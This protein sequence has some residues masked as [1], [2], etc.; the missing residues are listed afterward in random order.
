MLPSVNIVHLD[1]APAAGSQSDQ[2]MPMSPI[3][4]AMLPSCVGTRFVLCI[5]LQMCMMQ[6]LE[7]SCMHVIK[8]LDLFMLVMLTPYIK[9][10]TD[11]D[12]WCKRILKVL[13]MQQ[14]AGLVC[15][16]A[17]FSLYCQNASRMTF[18]AGFF[19]LYSLLQADIVFLSPPWGGP[20]YSKSGLFDVS[21]SIGGL[22]Q[23]LGQLL[24]TA[25]A[26]LKQSA[27]QNIACF[28][29]RN[30]DLLALSDT[31]QLQECIVERNV[32]NGHLKAVTAYYGDLAKS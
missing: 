28:L 6:T 19:I 22:G 25:S 17:N 3:H 2:V 7:P 29:P 21:Q 31:V 32:L 14:P 26:A 20:A 1:I 18:S 23:N 27:S 15:C 13:E 16:L 9:I 30:T 12:A 10:H 8:A 4:K 11:G 24:Q 5:V